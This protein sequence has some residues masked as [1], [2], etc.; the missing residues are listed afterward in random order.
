MKIGD[1]HFICYG[2]AEDVTHI[3]VNIVL[4]SPSI[5]LAKCIKTVKRDNTNYCLLNN[6]YTNYFTKA[7]A[8]KDKYTVT[9]NNTTITIKGTFN[10]NNTI[11]RFI[12]TI[13]MSTPDS[14]MNLT[15]TSYP[16]KTETLINT[17]DSQQQ[18]ITSLEQ[19]LSTYTSLIEQIKSTL[20][21]FM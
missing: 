1:S 15:Q 16:S 10:E 21:Y 19:Q 14:V 5:T 13:D 6:G 7:Y 4:T 3:S 17:I 9:I 11:I 2:T 8:E 18:T 12:S 20:T